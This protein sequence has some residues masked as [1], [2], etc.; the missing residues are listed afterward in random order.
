MRNRKELERISSM[1]LTIYECEKRQMVTMGVLQEK[2]FIGSEN[3]KKLT[4]EIEIIGDIL[5]ERIKEECKD[6][7]LS[8]YFW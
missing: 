5:K 6:K 1:L 7:D 3:Y 2:N 8:K 4:G